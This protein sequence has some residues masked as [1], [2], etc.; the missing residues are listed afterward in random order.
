MGNE[1]IMRDSAESFHTHVNVCFLTASRLPF[2]SRT[3]PSTP[4]ESERDS[5]RASAL[6]EGQEKEEREHVTFKFG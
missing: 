1:P 6:P 2:S 4:R 3:A 5:Q